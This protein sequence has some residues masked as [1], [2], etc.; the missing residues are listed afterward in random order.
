MRVSRSV[1]NIVFS[2]AL[3]VSVL[4]PGQLVAAQ[5]SGQDSAPG[6][7]E[8]F[9]IRSDHY[10]VISEVDR[11][12]ASAMAR[13]LEAMLQLY[14][15]QF[16]FPLEEQS[17]PFRVR[18]FSS[19]ERYDAYLTRVIRETRQGYVYLHYRDPAKSE[20]VGYHRSAGGLDQSLIHQSFVQFLRGF[21]QNPP[22]WLREGFAVYYEA[23][24]YDREIQRPVYRENLAWLETL[25]DILSGDS[26][27][28]VIS[29]EEILS[30]TQD[31]ARSQLDV[32]YPQAWGMVSF[33]V[34]AE[35]S[36]ANRMLWDSISALQRDATLE[37][38][39]QAV[40]EQAFRWVDREELFQE[41]QEYIGS[42]RSFQG[43]VT[44]GVDSFQD[45]ETSEAER[46][47]VQAIQLDEDSYVPYYYLGLINYERSNYGLAD[48][49]YQEAAARGAEEAITLYALGVNAYADNRFDDARSYLEETVRSDPSY[50]DRAEVI[51]ARIR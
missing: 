2:V 8:Q 13:R 21:I 20:L 31:D 36:D 48:Y 22:L 28:P 51:L 34:N 37:E 27:A 38:N 1:G 41:F 4:V 50:E 14:N 42:R 43:W 29:F 39:V 5:D 45:G 18:V 6:G 33:L 7:A 9:E 19:K 40:Y 46:A 15:G 16:R 24:D 47:F 12:H 49:Y 32:F 23:S 3:V 35:Y 17:E 25:K 30:M 26:S 10:H 44:H 11:D